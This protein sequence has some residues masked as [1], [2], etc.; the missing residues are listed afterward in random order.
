MSDRVVVCEFCSEPLRESAWD[1]P[2]GDVDYGEPRIGPNTPEPVEGAVGSWLACDPCARLI[3]AGSRDKLA[4]RSFQRL[5]ARHPEWVLMAGGR[6]ETLRN[7][8]DAHDRFWSARRGEPTSIGRE[9]I[10]L[11]STEP[12]FIRERRR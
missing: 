8:R 4:N 12:P 11:I 3:R 1:F 9:E 10:A 6:A 7:I 5:K 2:A